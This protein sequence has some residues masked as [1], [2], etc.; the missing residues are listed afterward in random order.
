MT[1]AKNQRNNQPTKQPTNQ[2][3]NQIKKKEKKGKS[4]AALTYHAKVDDRVDDLEH[5]CNFLRVAAISK[6]V[7]NQLE[8]EHGR[9]GFS[10]GP[11]LEA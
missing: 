7:L 1:E 11:L 2:P 5:F 10:S 3:T 6:R 8:G 9:Q 4:I